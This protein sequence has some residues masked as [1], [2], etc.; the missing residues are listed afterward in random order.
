M[1]GLIKKIEKRIKRLDFYGIY[2][3]PSLVFFSSSCKSKR[4][5]GIYSSNELR[6]IVWGWWEDRG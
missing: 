1:E 5:K 2:V 4:E 3:S 6:Q